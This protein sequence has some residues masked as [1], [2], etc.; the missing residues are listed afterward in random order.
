MTH[1]RV[2]KFLTA[3]GPHPSRAHFRFS[4]K[5]P[6]NANVHFLEISKYYAKIII[7]LQ[8]LMV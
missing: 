8:K 5:Q 7:F 1:K 6:L 4:N 3:R 2:L